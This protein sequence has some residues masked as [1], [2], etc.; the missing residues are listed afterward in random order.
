VG[1]RALLDGALLILGVTDHRVRVGA[2]A[3]LLIGL[4]KGSWRRASFGDPTSERLWQWALCLGI[5]LA[6]VLAVRPVRATPGGLRGVGARLTV[7]PGRLRAGAARAW[8]EIVVEG[9][10]DE[11]QMIRERAALAYGRLLAPGDRAIAGILI[12]ISTSAASPTSP[13]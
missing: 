3:A 5:A 12:D 4:V 2:F 6:I 11:L 9:W 7:A 13:R 10:D 1:E 8:Q